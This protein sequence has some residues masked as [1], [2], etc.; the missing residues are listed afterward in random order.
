MATAALDPAR[1]TAGVRLKGGLRAPGG[2]GL[3]GAK[4]HSALLI[5]R[6]CRAVSLGLS[7]FLRGGGA[8]CPFRQ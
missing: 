6:G 2:N 8:S 4:G 1:D 7:L 5:G 3:G